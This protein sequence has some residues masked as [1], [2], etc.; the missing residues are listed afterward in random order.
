[1]STYDDYL[2]G[3]EW[4]AGHLTDPNL[5]VCDCRFT[6]DPDSSRQ[7]YLDG[8]IPGAVY[9]CWLKELCADNIQVT[10]FLPPPAKAALALGRLGITADTDVIAYADNASLYAT[11]LWHV[12][13]HYGHAAVRLLDGGLE[14]WLGTGRALETGQ[15]AAPPVI[16]RPGTPQQAVAAIELRDRLHDPSLQVL[17]VRSAAEYE[18]VTVR[19]ARG[20]HIPAAILLPW[21]ELV[22]D[23]G[24]YLD[25]QRLRDRFRQAGLDPA[26]EI[27]TYCQGGIRAAHTAVALHLAGYDHVRIYDGSWAEW[28]NDP[29]LPITVPLP[30]R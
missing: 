7:A 8:H 14:A 6:G 21:D 22:D 4:L 12:L 29:T 2:V 23:G 5:R 28:G 19:A 24:R 27:V 13:R 1:M 18:G 11:R 16:F 10:T 25:V 30:T 20:G 15:V 17:D 3:P 26:R 9:S